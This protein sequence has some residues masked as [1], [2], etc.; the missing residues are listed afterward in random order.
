MIVGGGE[1]RESES[2]G[3]RE[4]ENEE[5]RDVADDGEYEG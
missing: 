4:G 3:E 5:G 1:M 2:E